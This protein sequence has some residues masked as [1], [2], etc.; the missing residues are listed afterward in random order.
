MI[1]RQCHRRAAGKGHRAGNEG[2][3]E[4]DADRNQDDRGDDNGG[5][6]VA[7]G[8]YAL[9]TA[10]AARSTGSRRSATPVAALIALRSAG[11]PAVAPVSPMPPGSSLLWMT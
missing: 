5:S 6:T 7:H 4:I 1:I 2:A 11:G 8:A 10:S 9:L 3:P